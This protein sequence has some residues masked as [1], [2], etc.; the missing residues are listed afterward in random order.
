[1]AWAG[2]GVTG[3]AENTARKSR[4]P[5]ITWAGGRSGLAAGITPG[6]G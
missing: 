4:E 3:L 5:E 6:L 1:M 2:A